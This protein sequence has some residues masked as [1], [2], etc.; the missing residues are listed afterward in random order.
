MN[1]K[2]CAPAD[3]VQ[4]WESI[5]WKKAEDYVKK[6]QMRIVK[7]QKS[8]HC[9]KV[10][11]LQ[12]LLTHSFYAKALAV[13]RVTSNKGKNTAGVDHE[14]WKTP[15]GKFAAISKLGRPLS[16]PT[17]TDRAMQTLYKFALEPLAE[18]LADPN[19]YGFRTGRSTHDAIGQCFNDLCRAKSPQWILEGDIKGCFDHISHKWLMENIPMD[20]EMLRKWL[21][22][23][24]VE[25]KKLFPT[26]EGTPQ[27]GTISRY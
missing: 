2:L 22:C 12:W 17:M 25:T 13:R 19:S 23:G 16:I 3:K 18:T 24:F 6:L 21:K 4:S 20:K 27:G 26:K 8:G 15:K 10:K 7:A 9:S 5:N 14:I 11:T 1:R